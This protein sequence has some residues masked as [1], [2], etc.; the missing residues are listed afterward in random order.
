MEIRSVEIE[1]KN[2]QKHKLSVAFIWV[3]CAEID[4]L[5]DKKFEK[6]Y[7]VTLWYKKYIKIS[8]LF[9]EKY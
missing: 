9:S 3:F 7:H 6:M 2:N 5:K 4:H 1:N 8:Y